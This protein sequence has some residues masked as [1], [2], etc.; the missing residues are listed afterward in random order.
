MHSAPGV[1]ALVVAI[2]LVIVG[3]LSSFAGEPL[4]IMS[5]NIRYGTAPDGENHWL[6]RR[7]FLFDVIR[8]QDADIVGLQ[9]ALDFQITEIVAAGPAYAAIGVGRDDAKRA[10][11]YAAILVRKDRLHIA[12]AGTF[13]FSDTPA[14]VGS[15]TWGNRIPRICTWARLIDRDGGAFWVY[16]VHLDHQSQPSR[17][18][19]TELLAR[20]IEERTFPSEP[21]VITGDFN[22]GE[23]NPAIKRLVSAGEQGTPAPFRDTFRV[24]HPDVKDAGTFSGFVAERISGPKIDYVL[25]QPGA[26]VVSATIVR[27]SRDGRTPSDHFPVIARV[28]LTAP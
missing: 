26:Q 6:K 21:V 10:G 15:T 14:I 4:T 3:A 19:S 17:E 12:D 23:D 18:K 5:F 11:E 24:L 2:V 1:R 16:N 7:E 13:W 9:E 25:V 20:R 22:T 27:T 8:E 28:R